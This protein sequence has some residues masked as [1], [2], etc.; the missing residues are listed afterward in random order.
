MCAAT[1]DLLYIDGVMSEVKKCKN[2]VMFESWRVSLEE[3]RKVDQEDKVECLLANQ[4]E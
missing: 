2:G 1:H 4:Q 3:I